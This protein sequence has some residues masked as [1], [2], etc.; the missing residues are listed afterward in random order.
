[1]IR[2]EKAEISLKKVYDSSADTF[3]WNKAYI[4]SPEIFQILPFIVYGPVAS[5]NVITDWDYIDLWFAL[6]VNA[7]KFTWTAWITYLCKWIFIHTNDSSVA[8]LVHLFDLKC[9]LPCNIWHLCSA[10]KPYFPLLSP[11]GWDPFNV[12][13]VDYH[14]ICHPPLGIKDFCDPHE[15]VSSVTAFANFSLF[16]SK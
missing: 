6:F 15:F 16:W 10:M 2:V 5:L 3:T 14:E 13:C 8:M 4:H 1:M 12:K 7:H 9:A 11:W